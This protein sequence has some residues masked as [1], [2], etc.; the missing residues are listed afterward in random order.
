V[1]AGVGIG[2]ID[3]DCTGTCHTIG[4]TGTMTVTVSHTFEPVTTAFLDDYGLGS[5]DFDVTA[6]MRVM[7]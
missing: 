1:P 2:D 4:G 6:S 5:V 7:T 3:V